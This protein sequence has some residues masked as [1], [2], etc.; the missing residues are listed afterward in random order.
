MFG[1]G[2]AG[3]ISTL[4][5]YPES[6]VTVNGITLSYAIVSTIAFILSMLVIKNEPTKRM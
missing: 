4:L 1:Y 5:S 6:I 3:T 2:L